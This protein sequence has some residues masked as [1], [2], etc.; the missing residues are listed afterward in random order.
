M[1]RDATTD[2]R[3]LR[4][5]NAA[6]ANCRARRAHRRRKSGETPAA[7]ANRRRTDR[8]LIMTNENDHGG[9]KRSTFRGHR[10]THRGRLSVRCRQDMRLW[11][12]QSAA[13]RDEIYAANG[14]PQFG[15]DHRG[16]APERQLQ[17][18]AR[19]VSV[20]STVNPARSMPKRTGAFAIATRPGV[21]E[22]S[23]SCRDGAIR[24][25]LGPGYHRNARKQSERGVP[26]NVIVSLRG[27]P[28]SERPLLGDIVR[29]ARMV[30]ITMS[31]QSFRLNVIKTQ[32]LR[33]IRAR[34]RFQA[35][36]PCRV[37]RFSVAVI[38]HPRYGRSW[39]FR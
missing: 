24:W 9:H 6:H 18:S 10:S 29:K 11:P 22:T 7:L 36:A 5:P 17:R 3:H 15:P 39:F 19:L 16:A 35:K 25:F 27:R 21:C 28:A 32:V 13:P 12:Q 1:R 31:R 26:P 30:P 20:I 14:G 4:I 8:L 38:V 37:P 2:L 33:N 34:R 23:K